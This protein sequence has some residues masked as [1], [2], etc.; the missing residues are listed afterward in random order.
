MANSPK[1]GKNWKI[2]RRLWISV[3]KPSL[4][5]E[6]PKLNN[7]LRRKGYIKFLH[8]LD[9][10]FGII[11]SQILNMNLFPSINNTYNMVICEERH[12]A[13]SRAEAVAFAAWV[14]NDKNGVCCIVCHKYGCS[15]LECFHVIDFP[16]W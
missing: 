10:P 4:A 15:S 13:I 16:D 3:M 9:P 5:N 2:M 11:S 8:G 6:L 14:T 12:C 7:Y 1:Y